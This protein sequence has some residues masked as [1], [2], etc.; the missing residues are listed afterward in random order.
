MRSLHLPLRR[1]PDLSHTESV[2]S[3]EHARRS[4]GTAGLDLAADEK[5]GQLHTNDN[6]LDQLGIGSMDSTA[7]QID[8]SSHGPTA[9]AES[10]DGLVAALHAQYWRAL[11]DPNATVAAEWAP[12]ADEAATHACA[13]DSHDDP[14]A[15]VVPEH[16]ESIEALL[17]GHRT[18]EDVFDRLDGHGETVLDDEPIPEIL[19]LFAP[20]EFQAAAAR[21]G[22]T[23]PPSLT[24]REHHALTVDSPL[25]APSL[26]DEG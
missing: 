15:H 9:A 25:S 5:H 12:M 23:L 18:L 26:K 19:R 4:P 16:A 7:A 20:P 13:P 24:R 3:K 2:I 10:P 11:T 14:R 6:V 1:P 22:P 8:A 21:R 17:F